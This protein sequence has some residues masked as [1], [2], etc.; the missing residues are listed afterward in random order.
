MRGQ[1]R[2]RVIHASSSEGDFV[3]VF[4]VFTAVAARETKIINDQ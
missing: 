1:Q 2:C 3:S 4:V